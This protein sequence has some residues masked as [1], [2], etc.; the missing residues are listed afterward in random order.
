MQGQTTGA[1]TRKG[2][3]VGGAT[4]RGL[5]GGVSKQQSGVQKGHTR[6]K[7]YTRGGTTSESHDNEQD[8]FR[9]NALGIKVDITPKHLFKQNKPEEKTGGVGATKDPDAPT[10]AG[11]TKKDDPKKK[12]EKPKEV[13]ES[14]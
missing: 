8:K 10:Q 1:K 14:Q 5:H 2:G 3:L 12:D 9:I 7:N 4:N 6:T 11:E 13:T